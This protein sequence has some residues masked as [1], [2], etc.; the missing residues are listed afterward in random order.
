MIW[1]VFVKGTVVGTWVNTAHKVWGEALAQEAMRHVGWEPNKIFLPT[2]EVDDAKPKA[3]VAYIANRT[4]KSLDDIWLSLGKDNAVT[5]AQAYP[6]FFRQESLYSFLRSM[7]DVHIVMVKRIPG[8][9]PPELL[10]EPI[11]EYCAIL[12]YRSKRGMFGYMKGLLAGAAEYFK[13]DIKTEIVESSAEHLKMLI[14][15]PKPITSTNIYRLN[16]LLSFGVTRSIPLKLGIAVGVVSLLI[17]GLLGAVGIDVPLWTALLNGALAAGGAALLLRPFDGIKAEI[18]NIQERKY[19]TET[20]IKSSDEFEEISELLSQ[21]KKRVKSEFIGFKGITDEM[22]KYGDDF[23]SLASRMQDTSDEISGVVNDVAMAATNQ[24]M[25]T[26]AA[27]GILNGNLETLRTVV[28]EQSH[29]KE[30]LEMAVDQINK[31][32]AEVQASSDKLELSLD[33]FGE[34]KRS[35]EHLQ[36][37][38]AKIT[39][40]TG[41]VAAIAGQTNLLALNAAIEAARAGEQGRGFA[42]VA[43]EVRKLAEQSHQHSESISSDLKVLMNIIGSVVSMIEEEFSILESETRQMKDVVAQNTRHVGNIHLVAENIVDM[44]TKLER[45]MTGLNEVYGKIESLAA[46]SEEN[47][48][49]TEE[50]SASVHVYNEKLHDMMGKITEFKTVI[51]HFSEDIGTYRT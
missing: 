45:E 33:K 29:N 41:M 21:Y 19:F 37:Q 34:V 7:Y 28:T 6:A 9:K 48:A 14:T 25:E 38:A 40:I 20:K 18:A 13:E 26:E 49:A 8:A 2:E 12:S 10:I 4:G 17:D 1:G 11:S 43:E 27:V 46:I 5:F 51:Q 23:N 22:N 32:F 44:I 50:V 39:E 47:S 15:F 30:Q 31:G 42:V 35:A 3:F 16:Q 24:A 36:N